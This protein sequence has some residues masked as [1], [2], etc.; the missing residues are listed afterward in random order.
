MHYEPRFFL[1][2][3][4]GGMRVLDCGFK[5]LASRPNGAPQVQRVV[6]FQD[7][8]AVCQCAGGLLGA[9]D[10]RTLSLRPLNHAG[11]VGTVD[12]SRRIHF[13]ND[14]ESGTLLVQ[15]VGASVPVSPEV[16]QVRASLRALE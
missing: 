10:L 5:E 13:F 15:K 6:G 11:S 9:L 14:L 4:A 3:S 8:F 2:L 16:A 1:S 12:F 7:E